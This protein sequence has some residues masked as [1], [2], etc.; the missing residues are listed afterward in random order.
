MH[1]LEG[2]YSGLEQK[3]TTLEKEK[4][5]TLHALEEL[6]ISLDAK[7]CEHDSFVHT[8]EVR[9]AGMESEMHILQEECQLRK[10]E[11]DRL[12][13]KA[14]ESDIFNFTLQTSSLDLEG[15]G[16][17]LLSEVK[18][19]SKEGSAELKLKIREKD[20]RGE[21]LEVE[22]CNLAKA[23]QLAED[24][25]K[26]VKGM[27]DQLNLQVNA[28]KNLLSEKDTELQGME[29]ML[30]LTE[31]EKALLHQILK[32]EVATFKEGS[33]ELKLKIREKDRRGEQLEIENCNLAKALQL[34]EDELKTVKSMT[35]QLNLQVNVSK[36]L[37]SEK[38]TEL[39]GMQQKLYLT[40]TEKALLHQILKSEIAAL[41][42]ASEELK[43]KIREKD[44]R[45]ETI[46]EIEN[47]NLA[48]AL[49]LAEDELKTVKS[50]RWISLHLK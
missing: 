12:L 1:D 44:H 5:L 31:T 28:G 20:H 37:L 47:F 10:Q 30:Y 40:E 27:M 34:A 18:L 6:R 45:G 39:Q 38:D 11:F 13:E 23:L 14:M 15:K 50:M 36:N 24:E 3:H 42:E 19:H 22:N 9:L 46:I 35:D 33:E 4:E 43:L 25:L 29:Q 21:L 16:S 48:K 8:T 17:S 49:Q 2:R 26:T 41:K 7:N 32:S